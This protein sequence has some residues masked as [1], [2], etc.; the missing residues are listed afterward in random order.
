ML[1]EIT[2]ALGQIRDARDYTTNLLRDLAPDDWFRTPHDSPTHIAWQVGHLAMAQYRLLLERIRGHRAS[3]DDLISPEFL[4]QFGKDSVPEFEP[5]KN[6]SIATIRATFDRVYE[7]ALREL[8][9]VADDQWSTEPVRPHRLFT[10]K[11][12]S[13]LWCSRHDMLHAGQIG[14]LRRLLGRQPQW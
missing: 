4:K 14:L 10:T 2:V 12:G 3:D 1:T 9:E 13:I 6:P 7:Q 8:P 5:A 11:L